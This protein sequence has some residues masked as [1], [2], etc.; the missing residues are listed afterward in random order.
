MGTTTAATTETSATQISVPVSRTACNAC[1]HAA[2]AVRAVGRVKPLDQGIHPGTGGPHRKERRDDGGRPERI[3]V[4]RDQSLDLAVEQAVGVW[5]KKILQHLDLAAN[6]AGVTG[7]PPDG[8]HRGGGGE[9]GQEAEKRHARRNEA[10]VGLKAASPEPQKGIDDG[11]GCF[12]HGPADGGAVAA[13][14]HPR[15]WVQAGGASMPQGGKTC[16]GRC[17]VA[18]RPRPVGGGAS[19]APPPQTA[20][21]AARDRRV[22]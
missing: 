14:C 17:G 10:E 1:Q 19:Q 12:D 5:R 13:P 16:I 18:F 6:D 11:V 21:G 7:E 15:V 2:A 9:D 22:W 8:D 20:L 4:G 3:A